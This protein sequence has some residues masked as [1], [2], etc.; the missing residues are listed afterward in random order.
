M[1]REIIHKFKRGFEF[2]VHHLLLLC[3][4]YSIGVRIIN[5]CAHS[6][7]FHR[8]IFQWKLK[9]FQRFLV[10]NSLVDGDISF[11]RFL[12]ANGLFPQIYRW[13]IHAA[14][15]AKWEVIQAGIEFKGLDR[16]AEAD[17][18]GRG[19]V[20][21]C[22]HFG[23]TSLIPGFYAR[24]GRP[25][26][27]LAH[28]DFAARMRVKLSENLTVV[29]MA[30]SFLPQVLFKAQSTLKEGGSVLLLPDGRL[31]SSA[32]MCHF[33][34]RSLPFREGFAT[35]AINTGAT[36]LP[37][38]A[39]VDENGFM[40]I[41]FHQEL[42]LGCETSPKS[43]RVKYALDQYVRWVEECWLTDP[44]NI[45][46]KQLNHFWES[47]RVQWERKCNARACSTSAMAIKRDIPR[48]N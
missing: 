33:F 37:T 10:L 18:R 22:A 32:S 23:V 47:P 14:Q 1:Y 38:R 3:L 28:T 20:L 19:V 13:R 40:R 27:V 2:F 16:L 48:S 17:R 34:D 12:I 9:S 11:R 39:T 8:T 36:V 7:L 6:S 44:G 29:S 5:S 26:L 41:E 30:N 35:L 45:L 42:A 21:V 4:P 43:V 15:R 24:L 46:E 31:G 25:V